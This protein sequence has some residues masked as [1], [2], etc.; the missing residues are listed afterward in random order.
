VG[1]S[2]G[3]DVGYVGTMDGDTV[4]YTVGKVDGD[5]DGAILGHVG[6]SVGLA[7]GVSVG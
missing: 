6:D 7:D 5:S 1:T 4:G 2:V 3:R